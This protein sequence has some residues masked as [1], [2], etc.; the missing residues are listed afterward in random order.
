MNHDLTMLVD[1][2]ELTMANGMF[3]DGKKDTIT[4]FDMFFRR[5]PDGGGF[6]I[7]AGIHQLIE[8]FENLE[9]SDEDIE[10]L[11][12]QKCFSEGF[13][14]YLKKFKFECDV[15]TIAEGTPIFPKEPIVTVRG[16]VIQAMLVETSLLLMINHQ[17]LIATK[18]NRIVRSAEG[19]PVVEFGARR[20]QGDTAATLGTRAAFIGGCVGT[21]NLEASKLFGIPAYGTMAH[22][23]IQLFDNEYKAFKVYAESYPDNCT[24]LIDTYN[25]LKSGLPNAI[26]VFDEVLK[27]MGK[28]PKGVRIDSGDMTYLSKKI[29]KVLDEA[30]Y[31]DCKILVSNSLDENI[32]RDME[33]QGAKIDN[34]CVGERLITASSEPVFGGV[35]KLVGVEENGEIKP[36]IKI[37]ENVGKITL[38]GFKKTWRLFDNETGKAIADVITLADEV[39]DDSKPYEIFDPVHTWKRKTLT[40][41]KAKDLMI[42]IF[43][44]GKKVYESPKV[45]EIQKYC[46]EQVATM[47]D[48]VLRFENP[49]E[50]Y[51]DL[52][53]RL[54]DMRAELLSSHSK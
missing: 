21:S 33:V 35:Y 53:Q 28:R 30:G 48:E 11:R 12:A 52:S 45:P 37:S 8:Y 2:Y 18:A 27:P 39:I 9:F 14:D 17:S 15:W 25:V 16:P 36:R 22:S 23:W 54:W 49:H 6:A 1:L 13:L 44:G 43:D 50:Y 51:V 41:F 34:Y 32:I 10:F 40:N 4:Y 5:V 20:A 26:K 29:R 46:K 19:K 47:W 7:L 24:V 42:K 38:P 3:L 31:P